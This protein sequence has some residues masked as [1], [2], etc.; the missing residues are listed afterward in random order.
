MSLALSTAEMDGER[1]LLVLPLARLHDPTLTPSRWR[2][3]V[4]RC[5]GCRALVDARGFARA[6]Y[7][8]KRVRDRQLVVRHLVWTE[9]PGAS[10]FGSVLAD[11]KALAAT[12]ACAAI[13]IEDVTAMGDEEQ[14]TAR[15]AGF[16]LAGSRLVMG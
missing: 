10:T 14:A 15:L 7:L 5:D 1:A 6:S 8:W 3:L 13:A 4:R 16:M 11:A 9:L 2:A 12:F